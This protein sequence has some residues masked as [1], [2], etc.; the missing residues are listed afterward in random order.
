MRFRQITTQN[1]LKKEKYTT[2]WKRKI[3]WL[4]G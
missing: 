1:C 3:M 2:R 4:A